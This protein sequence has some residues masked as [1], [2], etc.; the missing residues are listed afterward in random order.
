MWQAI[1]ATQR[2]AAPLTQTERACATMSTPLSMQRCSCAQSL[3]RQPLSA[4]NQQRLTRRPRVATCVEAKRGK[5]DDYRDLS[6][7][8]I[9]QQVDEAK[10]DLLQ[11]R[12]QQKMKTVSATCS[13]CKTLWAV[14]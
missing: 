1:T 8:E 5:A 10:R 3:H 2:A 11:L 7:D 4:L 14:W 6:Q 12:I 9:A 13:R